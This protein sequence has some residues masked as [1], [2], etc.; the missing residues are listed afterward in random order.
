MATAIIVDDEAPLRRYIKRLLARL[1]PT[2][3][4]RAEAV[5]GLDALE[6]IENQRPDIAF[7]DIQ[8]PGITGLEVAA[9]THN[10]CRIVFITAY[11]HYAIDAFEKAAVDYLL[12]PVTEERLQKTIERLQQ[13]LNDKHST[14]F[15]ALLTQLTKEVQSP[16]YLQWLKVALKED[17]YMLPVDEVDYF[18]AANKYTTVVT[19]EREWLIKTSIKALETALNPNA[20]WRI[21]RSTIVRVAAIARVS[22]GFQGRYLIEL[23][24]H[25]E[26]LTVSRA[27]SHRFKQM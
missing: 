11:D 8:M 7:L 3:E 27:Y 1:W 18:Q 9:Q 12:K 21:H 26:T 14:N 2:L 16:A 24:A 13:Q 22:R 19:A 4:I 6:L 23:H 20:F 17:I 10:A 5:N 15:Q 25:K